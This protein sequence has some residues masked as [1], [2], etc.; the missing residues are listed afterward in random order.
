MGKVQRMLGSALW[1]TILTEVE[2][3]GISELCT[4][5]NV[6]WKTL[7]NLIDMLGLLRLK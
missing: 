2:G 6:I 5:S 1:Q 3:K 4:I 7:K